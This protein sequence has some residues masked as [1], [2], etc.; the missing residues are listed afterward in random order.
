[1]IELIK[2]KQQKYIQYIISISISAPYFYVKNIHKSH[3]NCKIK[4][5][6]RPSATKWRKSVHLV[7]NKIRI[8][9]HLLE[10]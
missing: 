7:R 8:K 5:L 10:S 4:L 6:Y 3:K 2:E 9:T 1:M